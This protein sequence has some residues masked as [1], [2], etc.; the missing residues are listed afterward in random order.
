MR[1]LQIDGELAGRTSIANNRCEAAPYAA[2]HVD[3]HLAR[4]Q[5]AIDFADLLQ[6]YRILELAKGRVAGAGERDGS[7]MSFRRRQRVGHADRLV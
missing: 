3:F 4:Q 7:A 6:D 5:P 1:G 2:P